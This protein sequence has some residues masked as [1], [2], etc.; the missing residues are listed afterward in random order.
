[1]REPH[2]C[3]LSALSLF[4]VVLHSFGEFIAGRRKVTYRAELHSIERH[5]VGFRVTSPRRSVL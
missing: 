3:L 4:V 5:G 2:S 1:M